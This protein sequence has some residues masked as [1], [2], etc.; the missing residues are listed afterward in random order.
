[1]PAGSTLNRSGG[2]LLQSATTPGNGGAAADAGEGGAG[3]TAATGDGVVVAAG[4]DGCDGLADAF[5][6][7]TD[8]A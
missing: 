6:L 2:A 4:C 1:M 8:A 5:A 3:V 7:L